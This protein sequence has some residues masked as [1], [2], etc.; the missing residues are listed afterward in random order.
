MKKAALPLFITLQQ[1]LLSDQNHFR[2]PYSH[3]E[4]EPNPI[5]WTKKQHIDQADFIMALLV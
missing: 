1:L 2:S 5:S 3:F 4:T